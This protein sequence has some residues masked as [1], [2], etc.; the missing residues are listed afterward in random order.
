MSKIVLKDEN[1]PDCPIRNVLSRIGDKWSILVLY[2]LSQQDV[3]R[4]NQL[5]RS[6]PD[7][8]QK[9]L[10]STLKTLEA[11]G[12]IDRHAYPEVPPRVEYSISKR[13]ETL[14]P[15]IQELITWASQNMKKIVR[16]REKAVSKV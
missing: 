2:T 4:F 5:Q 15:I 12:I 1:F 10:T 7:I 3:S 8:S 16:S 9:M 14:L 6:I 11:D 13:G